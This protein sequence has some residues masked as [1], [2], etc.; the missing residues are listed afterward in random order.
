MGRSVRSRMHW[1]DHVRT[2]YV[3]VLPLAPVC[4]Y[5]QENVKRNHTE[6][7]TKVSSQESLCF[8][9]KIKS[10]SRCVDE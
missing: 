6:D 7:H 5:P 2:L 3:C 1:D 8:V 10:V 9:E 4:T